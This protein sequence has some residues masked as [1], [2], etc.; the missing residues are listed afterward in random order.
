MSKQLTMFECRSDTANRRGT[1]RTNQ[2]PNEGN[3]RRI[4]NTI[5]YRLHAGEY[6]FCRHAVQLLSSTTVII[7]DSCSLAFSLGVGGD[8]VIPV[9]L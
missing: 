4:T 5:G 6:G 1:V 7:N 2:L 3:S 9:E 8:I